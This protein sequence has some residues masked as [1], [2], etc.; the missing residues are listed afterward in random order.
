MPSAARG[1]SAKAAKAFARFYFAMV[2]YSALSGDTTELRKLSTRSCDS[3]TAIAD[4]VDAVYANGGRIESESWQL[5]SARVLQQENSQVVMS[6]AAFLG[7]EVFIEANGQRR[8]HKGGKQP[9]TMYV[10][11]R[12]GT[13][14]VTRLDLVT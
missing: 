5:N 8:H 3:C 2:N 1:T 4:K 12:H 11:L 9:M 13:S 7:P 14:L 10:H 6:L